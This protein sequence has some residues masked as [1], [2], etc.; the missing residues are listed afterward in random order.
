MKSILKSLVIILGLGAISLGS[1]GCVS[2][3]I[4][5]NADT[6]SQVE[7]QKNL[8]AMNAA[9]DLIQEQKYEEAEQALAA[10]RKEKLQ[11]STWAMASNN[12]GT[13]LEMDKKYS[14]AIKVF[15]SILVSDVND[16]DPGSNLMES[17]RNYRFKACIQ[18]AFCYEALGNYESAIDYIHLA[19]DK[20]KFEAD[21]GNCAEQAAESLKQLESR[22]NAEQKKA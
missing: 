17:F 3:R 4:A 8:D 5:Q 13:V 22:I 14:E 15:E 12:L 10:L 19:K 18:I 1:S 21:C 9:I 20:Y 2:H 11:K 7:T 6:A 16:R